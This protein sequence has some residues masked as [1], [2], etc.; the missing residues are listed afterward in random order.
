MQFYS[1]FLSLFWIVCPS[2]NIKL[3]LHK[4]SHVKIFTIFLS[5]TKEN[6]TWYN[7][8]CKTNLFQYVTEPQSINIKIIGLLWM[9][10]PCS[11]SLNSCELSTFIKG[12][13]IICHKYAQRVWIPRRVK[14]KNWS[15]HKK[16]SW[17]LLNVE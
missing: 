5:I 2:A 11:S 12:S 14:K 16:W 10:E 15:G 13:I 3:R 17:R 1:I 6:T 4:Y 8:E 7:D 9:L